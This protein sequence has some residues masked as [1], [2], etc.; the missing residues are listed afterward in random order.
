MNYADKILIS[1]KI[2]FLIDLFLV[3][4]MSIYKTNLYVY[5]DTKYI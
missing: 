4:F 3:L 5:Q 2:R 1:L